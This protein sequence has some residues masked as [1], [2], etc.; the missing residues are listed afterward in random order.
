MLI[1]HIAVVSTDDQS[2]PL[3]KS[4]DEN[5]ILTKKAKDAHSLIGIY[6]KF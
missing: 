1:K 6:Y 2:I 5:I 3:D 4:D